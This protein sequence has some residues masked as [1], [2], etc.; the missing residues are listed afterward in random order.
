[1]TIRRRCSLLLIT[2]L[3]AASVL[4]ALATE[5]QV[6][7]PHKAVSAV[8]LK[9]KPGHP[10][11]IEIVRVEPLTRSERALERYF[12]IILGVAY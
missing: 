10:H 11:N 12:P 7:P 5:L 3:L 1:M 6:S 8:S 2:A 9:K 4:P